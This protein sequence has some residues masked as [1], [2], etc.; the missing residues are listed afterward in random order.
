MFSGWSQWNLGI[1]NERIDEI[2]GEIK[3]KKKAAFG[4][5]RKIQKQKKSVEWGKILHLALSQACT[6]MAGEMLGLKLIFMDGGSGAQNPI[7]E[8]MIA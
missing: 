8:E 3:A 7:T 2:K 5:K 4:E 6:A 1:E